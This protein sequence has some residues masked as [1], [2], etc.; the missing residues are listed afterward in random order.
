LAGI[1][2]ACAKEAYNTSNCAVK[3]HGGT[4]DPAWFIVELVL[5]FVSA[6]F[7]T[8][9]CTISSTTTNKCCFRSKMSGLT[10]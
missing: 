7:R 5:E 4:T 3:T 9:V 8:N 10:I 1:L 6:P 2:V